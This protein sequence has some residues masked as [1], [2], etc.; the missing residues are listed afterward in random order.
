MN[1]QINKEYSTYL[2]DKMCGMVNST[3]IGKKIKLCGWVKSRREHG[4]IVF[5]DIKDRSGIVQVVIAPEIYKSINLKLETLVQII[6]EV[7]NRPEEMINKKLSTGEIEIEVTELNLISQVENLPFIPEDNVKAS[8]ELR[9]KHRYLDL[10]R[11]TI[12]N[13]F[14]IRHKIVNSINTFLMEN[15]FIEIE[16]PYLTAPT[17]EGA[18]NYLV[19][20]R[21]H[22]G[23][24]YSLAQSPQLYKQILMVS[25]VDRY[26]QFARCFRDE[27]LR[28]DRQPEH[29]Q[30]DIEMSFVNQ[31]DVFF[32]TERLFAFVFKKVLDIDITLPFKRLTY[33][34]SML[35]Y[36]SDKPDLRFGLE[37]N[38]LTELAKKTEMKLLQ[39]SKCT[40][41]IFVNDSLPSRKII[42]QYEIIAK[43][44]GA[45]GLLWAKINNNVV[46]GPFSKFITVEIHDLLNIER[47]NGIYYIITG[48]E[49]VVEKVLGNLRLEIGKN[50]NLIKNDWK[51]LWIVDYPLFE[52]DDEGNWTPAHHIFTM[53]NPDDI[54]YLNE[55]PGKVKGILYDLVL[56]GVELASG[57]IRNHIPKLQKQLFSIIG[58]SDKQIEERFG[59]LLEAFK[60]GAPPHGGIAPGLDR[61]T[62]L[63]TGN[64]SITDVIAFPKTLQAVG[65][66]EECPRFVE[67]EQL[68]ELKL[69]IKEK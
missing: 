36:G 56:N 40:R 17:P 44:N 47:I 24:F 37:I 25:G 65:L 1:P 9:F 30:I 39:N 29:T 45:G 19:P 50:E 51:F 35:K 43:E 13:N 38:E 53:P 18:R 69:K 49:K 2:R 57:S 67:E 48:E 8:I 59:F 31:E 5:S 28:A 10:R 14:I 33:K 20:S 15:N 42:Q 62:M 68:E 46:S 11:D 60:Y 34:E 66:M 54:K 41:G 63:M 26:Y 7:K 27:D 4:G 52:L 22:H 16:T 58:L 55:D 21:I 3:D 32:L 61:L 6:G 64:S 23:K 12:L